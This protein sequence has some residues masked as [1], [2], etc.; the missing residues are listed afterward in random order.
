MGYD[1]ARKVGI[2]QF[3]QGECLIAGIL[4]FALKINELQAIEGV[5]EDID[6]KYL[7]FNLLFFTLS[8]AIE[9][10]TEKPSEMQVGGE[11][12]SNSLVNNRTLEEWPRKQIV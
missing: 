5:R 10:A 8:I 9:R 7:Q 6:L 2:S 1:E 3:I 11:I 12:N 4:I